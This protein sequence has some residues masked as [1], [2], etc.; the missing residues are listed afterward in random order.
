MV[1]VLMKVKEKELDSEELTGPLKIPLVSRKMTE[2]LGLWVR[3][4]T[5]SYPEKLYPLNH[6]LREKTKSAISGLTS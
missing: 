4:W 2:I 1:V 3:I 6:E 5:N